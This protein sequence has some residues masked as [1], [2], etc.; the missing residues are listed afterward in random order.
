MLDLGNPLD[1]LGYLPQASQAGG[2]VSPLLLSSN[3]MSA[4]PP[5]L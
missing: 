4:I 1:E 3:P 2:A 5:A